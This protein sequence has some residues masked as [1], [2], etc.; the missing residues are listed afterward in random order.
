M[1]NPTWRLHKSR[2]IDNSQIHLSKNKHT[3]LKNFSESA[4]K[5]AGYFGV[6]SRFAQAEGAAF[7]AGETP[8]LVK[9]VFYPKI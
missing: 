2:E 4:Q 9:R 8:S 5:P 7:G 1:D 3:G 6:S